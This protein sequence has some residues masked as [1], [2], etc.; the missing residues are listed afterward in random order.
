MTGRRELKNRLLELRIKELEAQI[1]LLKIDTE[2]M[3]LRIKGNKLHIRGARNALKIDNIMNKK[4]IE[5]NK[6]EQHLEEKY[7]NPGKHD[8]MVT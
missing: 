5:S 6:M 2:N 3:K 7:R 1:E 4:I 8:K